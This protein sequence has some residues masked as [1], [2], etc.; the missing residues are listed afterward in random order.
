MLSPTNCWKGTM[1]E[2]ID[3]RV[4][5]ENEGERINE[6]FNAGKSNARSMAAFNWQFRSIP[7]N[8]SFH[9]IA[10]VNGEI[11]GIQAIMSI[12]LGH[13]GKQILSG[14][15]EDTLLDP[16]MRG[17]GVFAKMYS[18][19]IEECKNRNIEC[20]WGFTYA[21]RAFDKIGFEIP[22]QQS[23]SLIVANVAGAYNY[24]S[25]RSNQNSFFRKLKI[26][27]LCYLSYFKFKKTNGAKNWKTEYITL[28]QFS[29]D[30]G[31]D[32]KLANIALSTA[33]LDWRIAKNP[34]IDKYVVL[35]SGDGNSKVQAIVS[36]SNN[37]VGH[38]LEI[39]ASSQNAISQGLPH[40]LRT[41]MKE[42]GCP[43]YR[44]WDF[45]H[46]S[47][48]AHV[49]SQLNSA[50]MYSLN[51]GMQMVW[52]NLGSELKPEDFYLSYLASEGVE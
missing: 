26:R 48:N 29:H 45:A 7:H 18:L 39:S 33:Y 9:V 40:L 42:L 34:H 30:F 38:L 41:A 2:H 47:K 23:Q 37:E 11:M 13:Q 43:L 35:S 17:K 16:R 31:K 14:K 28:E 10:E 21:T 44:S 1:T 15:S 36:R 32:E 22:Y 20:I 12:F 24:L 19:L 3:I 6:F 51:L 25:R 27:A 49:M 5:D 8:K 46:N 4:A 52:L 50:G